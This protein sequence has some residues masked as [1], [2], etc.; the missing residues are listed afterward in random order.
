LQPDDGKSLAED[1]TGT[2]FSVIR[3]K[4][5]LKEREETGWRKPRSF[6]Q[7][8]K[9]NGFACRGECARA[10]AGPLAMGKG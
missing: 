8:T 1:A 6:D 5:T 2:E 4:L 3:P 9:A 7:K 10:V